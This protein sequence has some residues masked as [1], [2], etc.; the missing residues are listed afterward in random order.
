MHSKQEGPTTIFKIRQIL[1]L[2]FIVFGIIGAAVNAYGQWFIHDER[3]KMMGIVI[4]IIAMAIKM[5]ECVLR[6]M[7]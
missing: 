3:T 7:K 2:L 1:N 4:V 5:A 6:Y